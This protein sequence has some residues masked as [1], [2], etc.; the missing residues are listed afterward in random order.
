MPALVGKRSQFK[1]NTGL[2]ACQ[3]LFRNCPQFK[4]NN[5]SVACQL[6]LGI[7]HYSKEIL[8]S[9]HFSSEVYGSCPTEMRRA[10]CDLARGSAGVVGLVGGGGAS[11]GGASGDGASEVGDDVAQVDAIDIQIVLGGVGDR[12]AERGGRRLLQRAAGGE[13]GGG[14][15]GGRGVAPQLEIV[16]KT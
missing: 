8:G 16:S 11:G 9:W 6:L 10:P 5:G 12:L 7:G 1:R 14:E 3:L 13:V 15:G 2:E 4:T